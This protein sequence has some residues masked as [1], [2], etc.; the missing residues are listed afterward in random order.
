MIFKFV[1]S[2]VFNANFNNISV[3]S[4]RT[5]LLVKETRESRE[6]HWPVAS[7]WQ[8][9]SHNIVHPSPWSRFELI[10]SVVI[11]TDYIGSCKYNY[12]TITATTI[13]LFKFEIRYMMWYILDMYYISVEFNTRNHIGGVMFRVFTLSV[14]DRGFKVQSCQTKDY[15]ISISC[16]STK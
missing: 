6:N 8:T 4:W 3:I 12:H 11:G 5:V 14:V 1:C 7:H 10:A 2:M 9:L 16:F 15:T 13:P